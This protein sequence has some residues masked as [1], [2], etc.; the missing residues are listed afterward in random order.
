MF[1]GV[2]AGLTRFL[3]SRSLCSYATLYRYRFLYF[4]FAVTYSEFGCI[5]SL[6]R[7]LSARTFLRRSVSLQDEVLNFLDGQYPTSYGEA[8]NYFTAK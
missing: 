6:F 1:A 8:F 2:S 3:S 4:G 7:L 5:Y